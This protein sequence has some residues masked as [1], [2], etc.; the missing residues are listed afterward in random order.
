MANGGATGVMNQR[1]QGQNNGLQVMNKGSTAPRQLS[2]MKQL[3]G[4]DKQIGSS[5]FSDPHL[6][7]AGQSVPPMPGGGIPNNVPLPPYSG[8]GNPQPNTAPTSGATTQGQR[9]PS[10]FSSSAQGI[11]DAMAGARNEMNYLPMGIQS[12]GYNASQAGAKGVNGAR[13]F[14]R[15]YSAAG[16]VGQGYTASGTSGEGYQAA[17][18]SGRGF[19]AAGVDSQ[20]FKGAGVGSQGYNP[21]NASSYGVSGKMLG[22]GPNVSARDVNADRIVD[23]D[24]GRYM[25]PYNDE[26][27][28]RTLGDLDEARRLQMGQAGANA[29][30]SGAFGGSRHALR[31]SET[32]S[33]FFDQAARTAA[34]LRQQ[35]FNQAQGMAQQDIANKMQSDLANQ[36]ASLQADTTTANIAQ[37]RNLADQSTDLRSQEFSAGAKNQAE[38]AN[39]AAQNQAGQFAAAAANQA[40]QQ[41]SAQDQQAR[42]FSSAAANQAAQ[43]RSSQLQQARQFGAQAGNTS[44]LA[45]QASLNQA[46]QFGA[47]ARNTAGLA[48]QAALNAAGQ[49]GAQALNTSSLANQAARNQAGQFGAQAFNTANLANQAST[50][51]ANQFSAN[52]GNTARLA[53]QAASNR[54]NEFNIGQNQAAQMA[55]QAASLAAS[56]QRLS[57]GNQLGNLANLGFGMGQT[58]SGNLAQDGA[59]KQGLNQLLIDAVKNQFNQ[60]SQAPYQSIGLLSQA[61]GAS[62]VPQTTTTTKQP[63]LFDYLTL[64][65]S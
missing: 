63:G 57:S 28:N 31:E 24:I 56:Q 11:N 52:A 18:A 54:A 37:Q 19:D 30:A 7:Q 60:R 23:A 16:S 27:V 29:T 55:N 34:G 22:G 61:L 50:N 1:V 45:N 49:F 47:G 25:N 12:Q 33:S 39:Q 62:P 65:A 51:Q 10:I 42:Q 20:G 4:N 5:L 35:G 2:P 21:Q 48:N 59:M 8:N 38:F 41:T 6:G 44:D 58:L 32:N 40:A 43:Q 53:N 3:T 46:R 14:G 15:G 26:V 17:G 64:A 13:T 9:A 36:G